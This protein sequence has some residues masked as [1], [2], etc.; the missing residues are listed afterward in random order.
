MQFRGY[1]LLPNRQSNLGF[2]SATDGIVNLISALESII[3]D[4]QLNTKKFMKHY[5]D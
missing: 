5:D 3:G 1:L 4:A 2:G